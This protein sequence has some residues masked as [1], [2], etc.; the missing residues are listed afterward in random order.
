MET[1]SQSHI[2]IP[3]LDEGISEVKWVNFEQ[4]K[5]LRKLI[6]LRCINAS[7]QACFHPGPAGNHQQSFL[8]PSKIKFVTGKDA[9]L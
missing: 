8:Q 5:Y 9:C 2:I 4:I 7:F 3:Q 6:R 1:R